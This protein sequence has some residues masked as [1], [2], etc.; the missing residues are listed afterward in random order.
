MLELFK[1]EGR[2]DDMKTEMWLDDMNIECSDEQQ[3]KVL[4]A[5]KALPPSNTTKEYIKKELSDKELS[6]RVNLLKNVWRSRADNPRYSGE[7][8]TK[9]SD[10]KTRQVYYDEIWGWPDQIGAPRLHHIIKWK[11]IRHE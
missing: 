5:Y 9:W 4:R 8:I 1:Q 3:E 7:Y 11:E 10:K 6:D 2:N